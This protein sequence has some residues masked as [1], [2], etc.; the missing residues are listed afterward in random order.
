ML[1][2][3][4]LPFC[5]IVSASWISSHIYRVIA[6][7][8]SIQADVVDR[9]AHSYSTVTG[10]GLALLF[11]FLLS[12]FALSEL[13]VSH[14]IDWRMLLGP[15]LVCIYGFVDDRNDLGIGARLPIYVVA[16]I[17]SSIYVGFPNLVFFDYELQMGFVGFAFGALSLLWLQNLFNFM[18]GIDGFAACEVIFVCLAAMLLSSTI[19]SSTLIVTTAVCCGYLLI[20]W[21]VARVFMGDAGSN[22]FGLLL[23]IFALSEESVSLWVWMILL[24]QFLVDGCLTISIRAYRRVDI[25]QSHSQHCYQHM[26]RLLG[27]K[28]VLLAQAL[29]NILWLLPLAYLAAEF[30][31]YGVVLL[32]SAAV[33]LILVF[34]FGGAGVDAPRL[35][36]L[37]KK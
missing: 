10:S 34:W 6:Q 8:L 30:P 24:A 15:A 33:P 20:N 3:V 18:D 27:T 22:F 32:T 23:G 28:K 31:E 13:G 25:R 16:A 7:R 11:I 4:I 36:C 12:L 37:V 17:G 5:L 21:P 26:N 19:P 35:N 1:M 29:I 2:D 14:G 9:S